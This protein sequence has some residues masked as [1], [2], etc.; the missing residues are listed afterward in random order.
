MAFDVYGTKGALRWNLETM[1]QMEVF[2]VDEQGWR[3]AATP[4]CTPA[5]AIRIMGTSFRETPT[6]SDTKT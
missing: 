1:N 2:L 6:P 3:P 4:R 5:T